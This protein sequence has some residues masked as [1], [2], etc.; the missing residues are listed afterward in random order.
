MM[1]LDR[2]AVREWRRHART[3][4]QACLWW[5]VLMA[6]H[7]CLLL[8]R[9]VNTHVML[10]LLLRVWH[11]HIRH[12]HILSVHSSACFSTLPALRLS[13]TT[14]L[15]LISVF[16][17]CLTLPCAFPALSAALFL[18][19]CSAVHS[20]VD[21]LA[22]FLFTAAPATAV[23]V[24][25]LLNTA[26]ASASIHGPVLMTVKITVIMRNRAIRAG[27]RA[28]LQFQFGSSTALPQNIRKRH[29]LI[30]RTCVRACAR[31]RPRGIRLFLHAR[32]WCSVL[33]CRTGEWRGS[34]ASHDD[35]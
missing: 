18:T 2:Y 13:I 15:S 5:S 12:C 24:T 19:L 8:L 26:S 11:I 20:A 21:A 10:A 28:V 1:R 35:K 22:P 14:A 17:L 31:L 34:A 33:L 9:H 7:A 4:L 29:H 23:T 27:A 30:P 3:L 6:T 16:C 32:L 25:M